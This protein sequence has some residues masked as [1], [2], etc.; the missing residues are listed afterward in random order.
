MALYKPAGDD[1]DEGWTRWVLDQFE[2]PFTSAD[3]VMI[4][5]G[6]LRAQFDAI[7]LPNATPERIL[8]GMVKDT[9]PLGYGGGL[10]EEGVRELD[11][12]VKAGGTLVCLDQ[13][14]GVCDRHVQ[15]THP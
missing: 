1:N 13:A 4:R 8:K 14:G 10:G 9:V 7:I 5:A 3:S 6:D 12:F 15:T 11:A 2:F